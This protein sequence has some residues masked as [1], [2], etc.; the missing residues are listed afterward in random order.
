MQRTTQGDLFA[1]LCS[2]SVGVSITPAKLAISVISP[3]ALTFYLFVFAFAYSLV[4]LF[5]KDQR[6]II[7]SIQKD[8]M[9]LIMQLAVLFSVAIFF[10]WTALQYLEPVTQSFLSRIKILLTVLLAVIILKEKLLPL[11]ITGG[12][13]AASGLI[14]LKFNAGS[15]VS[16]GATLMLLSALLFA[17]AEN[18]LK[19]KIT[20][21]PPA[22]FLFFRNFL[23]IP[24]F[25]IIA[26]V[27]GQSFTIPDWTTTGWIALTSLLAPFFGRWLY[28]LAIRRNSLSRTVLINQT[29]P[30]F[31]ALAGYVIL[32]SIPGLMEWLGG[33]LILAGA[34]IIRM[35]RSNKKVKT[36][37]S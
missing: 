2:L 17:V 25:G 12:L 20:D 27:R 28:I 4:F 24:C 6:R 7:F 35:A 21:I 18:M 5:N 8:Q 26:L 15:L 37:P 34:M 9:L 3:E 13:V 16:K 22:K 32:N 19:S 23:M 36:A 33:G 10:S 14:L 1:V 31:A 11:E 29:Q 30:L